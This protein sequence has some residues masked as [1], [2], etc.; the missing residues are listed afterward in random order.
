MKAPFSSHTY[1]FHPLIFFA[2]GRSP[3]C[4][5]RFAWSF[6][7]DSGVSTESYRVAAGPDWPWFFCFLVSLFPASTP[8]AFLSQSLLAPRVSQRPLHTGDSRQ[9]ALLFPPS[10]RNVFPPSHTNYPVLFCEYVVM[11]FF[12]SCSFSFFL[13]LLYP[14]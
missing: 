14:L 11:C 3:R 9:N 13:S 8:S 7:C 12:T 1:P 6:L 4:C 5:G 2:C 10:A